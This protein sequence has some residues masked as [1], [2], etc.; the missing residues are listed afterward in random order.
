MASELFV[1]I[2]GIDV[3]VLENT[4]TE[5]EVEKQGAAD[6]GDDGSL[7]SSER[8][9]KRRFAFVGKFSPL[10][11]YDTFLAA[12][13]VA[14]QPGIPTPVTVTGPAD[15]LTRGATITAHV[16]TGKLSY[17]SKGAGTTKTTV[18]TVAIAV[19]EA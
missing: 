12:I 17:K 14:G 18:A 4:A 13:S 19:I 3:D 5:D 10:S 11:A 2:A 6:R 15:G 8:S 1:T 16:R 7:Q 9:P